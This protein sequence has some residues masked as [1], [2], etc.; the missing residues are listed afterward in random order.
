MIQTDLHLH[1]FH[2]QRL[3]DPGAGGGRAA[4][5][6]RDGALGALHSDLLPR[7]LYQRRQGIVSGGA[8]QGLV[9][10]DEAKAVGRVEPD[11]GGVA[12]PAFQPCHPALLTIGCRVAQRDRC[13]IGIDAGGVACQQ[14]PQIPHRQVRIG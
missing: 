9:H 11:P 14:I 2:R 4:A 3:L 12:L 7:Q 6:I 13:L 1:S 8:R 10:I 5:Q